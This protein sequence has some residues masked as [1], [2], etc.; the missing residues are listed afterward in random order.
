[1]NIRFELAI[2]WRFVS[3]CA[4]RRFN[5][6]WPKHPGG[7]IDPAKSLG[8]SQSKRVLSID[9]TFGPIHLAENH[10]YQI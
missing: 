10:L 6:E 9:T 2:L 4:S 7:W 3:S 8:A 5:F 1:M